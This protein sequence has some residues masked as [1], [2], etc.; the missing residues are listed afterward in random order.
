MLRRRDG[1]GRHRRRSAEQGVPVREM[2]CITGVAPNRLPEPA[3]ITIYDA[4][5]ESQ[6]RLLELGPAQGRARARCGADARGSGPR[7]G[8]VHSR[9]GE[10][11][12]KR[13]AVAN[14]AF[15]TLAVDGTTGF[16]RVNQ[17]AGTA[18]I[19]DNFSHDS[20]DVSDPVIDIAIVSV[21]RF[22]T[23]Q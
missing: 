22:E 10:G 3:I 16:Y 18:I 15:A 2:V 5:H 9:Q 17:L 1:V 11:L 7:R 14:D 12:R 19:I 20:D 4:T 6:H 13:A 21:H 23:P 8:Q